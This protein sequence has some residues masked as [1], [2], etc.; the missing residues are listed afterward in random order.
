MATFQD[1]KVPQCDIRTVFQCD[2][3][4]RDSGPIRRGQSTVHR[5]PL[6]NAST[7]PFAPNQSRTFDGYP[8]QI[9]AHDQA[10]VEMAVA[11]ILVLIPWIRFG[12][13]VTSLRCGQDYRARLKIESRPTSE[14]NCV[15]RVDSARKID[16]PPTLAGNC[17]QSSIDGSRLNVARFTGRAKSSH[18]HPVRGVS[19]SRTQFDQTRDAQPEYTS[20]IQNIRHDRSIFEFVLRAWRVQR[21]REAFRQSPS[22]SPAKLCAP[23]PR[24]DSEHDAD[25]PALETGQARRAVSEEAPPRQNCNQ[26]NFR[27][28]CNG[29]MGGTVVTVSR[30][31]AGGGHRHVK[32]PIPMRIAVRRRVAGISN[33]L[34]WY[35]AAGCPRRMQ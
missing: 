11:E 14:V 34:C 19:R 24:R 23:L 6:S 3:F 22:F 10:I 15:T 21:R 30:R 7:K 28:S 31:K 13:I 5:P 1:G 17:L 32:M 25:R 29:Q 16:C 20:S 18:T 9:A 27:S 12:R 26:H 35:A 33:G 2:R 8:A 4:I